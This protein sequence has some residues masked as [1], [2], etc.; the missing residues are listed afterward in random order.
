VNGIPHQAIRS[1]EQ[2]EAIEPVYFVPYERRADRSPGH[3]LV[4]GAGNGSD[5]AIALEE[6][7]TRVT[8]VEID[9]VLLELGGELNPDR[10]YDDPRVDTVV[11][12]GRAFLERTDEQFD[13]ILFA[14][15]DSL[16]LVSGQ[17]SV[18]L[19]SYLFTIEAMEA[20]RD[21][22]VEGGVFSMYNYYRE[23]WLID[24][25]QAT[26]EQAYG[27]P[28]CVDLVGAGALAV[29][30]IG[31]SPGSVICPTTPTAVVDAPAPSTDDYPFPYL[32][33]PSIP[34]F[35]LVTI[36]LIL[37]LSALMIRLVGGRP[38]DVIRYGDLFLMGAAFLLLETKSVV[39]FAL[40]FG[41]T[42]F[43]NALV[44]GGILLSVLAA[45]EVT[46]RLRLPRAEWLYAAL[47]LV[48][49]A[50][51]L[52]P[53]N[54]VLGLPFAIRF[55]AAIVIWFSPIFLANLI[56]AQRFARVENSA[57]AFGA[58][59]LGAMAGGVLEYMALIYGYQWLAFLVAILYVGALVAS[60]VSLPA[61]FRARL[62]IET[63]TS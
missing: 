13:T 14:L 12:D 2:R 30:T 31:A 51:W 49:L 5:V 62:E 8:A 63:P 57:G 20:A 60:R 29:L 55:V 24:R 25:L 58:N 19:E 52:V 34:D 61:L 16:T 40:L 54:A 4:I 27:H 17:S 32:R 42:W 1:V 37:V 7:A 11:D 59:L 46:R 3:V 23:P 10:P 50:G 41:T 47:V 44:F 9:P 28:P 45:I 39:Q 33:S 26:L 56:F 18:R 53:V 22:L 35:Y 48:V 36:T 15:P 21:R 6:G 43:V 38:G